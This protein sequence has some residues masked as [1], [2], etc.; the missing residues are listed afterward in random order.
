MLVIGLECRALQL[1]AQL[2][3]NICFWSVQEVGP[4]PKKLKPRKEH[5]PPGPG[6]RLDVEIALV[7][8][9]AAG[10]LSSAVVGGESDQPNLV[11]GLQPCFTLVRRPAIAFLALLRLAAILPVLFFE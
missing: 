7:G 3:R 11:V 1:K 4:R 8:G 5:L 2:P 6:E 10:V 9:A